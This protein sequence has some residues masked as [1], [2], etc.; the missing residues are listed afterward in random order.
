M[1]G[2]AM[3][4]PPSPPHPMVSL[5]PSP[6]DSLWCRPPVPPSK[7][8]M[9]LR[10]TMLICFLHAGI[11]NVTVGSTTAPNYA[12]VPLS[13]ACSL[14]LICLKSLFGSFFRRFRGL[15]RPLSFCA[16]FLLGALKV[17]RS[18]R[19]VRLPFRT[20]EQG[21]GGHHS[22]LA[23]GGEGC[24]ILR[25]SSKRTPTVTRM[26][27]RTSTIPVTSDEGA[28]TRDHVCRWICYLKAGPS[29]G[30]GV[31][32]PNDSGCSHSFDPTPLVS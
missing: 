12:A 4:G 3:P 27:T 5:P 24:L 19:L 9:M 1:C 8:A 21:T 26:M 30:A 6:C 2:A 13:T 11:P 22:H 10:T 18:M 16:Q 15:Y 25:E 7:M 29:L 14:V 31:G 28:A 32:P 17:S 20:L 23:G